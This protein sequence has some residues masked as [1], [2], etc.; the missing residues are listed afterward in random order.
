MQRIGITGQAGFI[1]THLFNYLGLQ[2][3][4][5]RI[6]FEDAYFQDENK[7]R[8]F[9]K[10]C[11]VIVHLAAMNRHNDPEVLYQT[12]VQLVKQLIQAME[13][14]AVKPYILF[15]SSTQEERDNLYG[16]SKQEGRE[17]FIQWA[18]RNG[19]RFIGLVI[20]NVFGPFGAPYYNSVIATFSHQLTHNETPKIETDGMLKL[21]YVGELVTKVW[22]LI[23]EKRSENA[24]FIDPT[25]K[26]KVLEILA[27]LNSYHLKYLENNI[28][29]ELNN[30]FEINLFNTFRSYIDHSNH[31]PVLHKKNVDNRG[32]FV[33]IIRALGCGQFSVSYPHQDI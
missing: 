31:F 28:I 16:R 7:L 29:P 27:L 4:V 9:V 15:S 2:D 13:S 6:V 21:I 25:S 26:A 5:E 19:A 14:E 1:G 24:Y 10:N 32:S 30:R 12:N 22:E 33:E 11:D 8:T 18:E 23:K 20:P 3:E 17:L